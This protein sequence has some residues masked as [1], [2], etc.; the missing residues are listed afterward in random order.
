MTQQDRL[1]GSTA[2]AVWLNRTGCVTQQ[3]RL[4]RRGGVAQQDRLCGSTG[5]AV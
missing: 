3:D 4:S 1:C 5:Q 2:Q